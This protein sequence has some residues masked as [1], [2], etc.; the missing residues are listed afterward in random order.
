MSFFLQRIVK[1]AGLCQMMGFF[2]CGVEVRLQ[3]DFSK[4]TQTQ[5]LKVGFVI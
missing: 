5:H 1:S 4:N 3:V 2:C